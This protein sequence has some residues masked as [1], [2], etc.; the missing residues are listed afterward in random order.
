MSMSAY[1]GLSFTIFNEE[2]QTVTSSH[3]RTAVAAAMFALSFAGTSV[4]AQG[5]AAAP[6]QRGTAG[7]ETPYIVITTFQTND[8]KLGVQ[9]A[10]EVRKRV[11]GAYSAKDLFVV[12]EATIRANL[13]ASGY[14]P[15]SALN[16]A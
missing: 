5:R 9:A 11:Q 2:V 3:R 6:A 1:N 16:E 10:E 12:P 15:D 7:P 14:P 4:L 13:I 8:R